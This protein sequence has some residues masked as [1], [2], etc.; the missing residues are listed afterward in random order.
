MTRDARG[1]FLT[2]SVVLFACLVLAAVAV[3]RADRSEVP[4]KR[5]TLADFPMQVG[6]WR[7][8]VLP[9]FTPSALAVLGLNDYLTRDYIAPDRSGVNLYIG[10]WESQRQGDT[11]HSPLNCL[12]GAGWE[13]LSQTIISVPDSRSPVGGSIPLNRV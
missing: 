12:P 2:R 1:G 4:P 5:A 9:P 10:Y 7:A 3:A 13:P 6:G 11:I 8:F